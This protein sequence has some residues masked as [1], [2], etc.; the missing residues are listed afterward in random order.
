MQLVTEYYYYTDEQ[1]YQKNH[2]GRKRLKLKVKV[3]NEE[4]GY[5]YV[6]GLD[7]FSNRYY[8]IKDIIDSYYSTKEFPIMDDEKDPFWDPQEPQVVGKLYISLIHAACGLPYLQTI[9][10]YNDDDIVGTLEVETLQCDENG[11]PLS[12]EDLYERD[13]IVDDPI[14]LLSKRLDILVRIKKC[15]MPKDQSLNAQVEYSLKI[16]ETVEYF[17]TKQLKNKEMS[18]VV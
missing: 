2:E 18:G 13:M 15:V 17:S 1:K 12:F 3:L 11:K 9:D 5:S 16:G 6:W 4:K 10:V 8:M 7:V 14:E